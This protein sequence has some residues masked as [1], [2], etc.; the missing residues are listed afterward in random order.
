MRQDEE[1]WVRWRRYDNRWGRWD[2][3]VWGVGLIAMGLLF[4]SN[5]LGFMPWGTWRTWWPALVIFL[6]VVRLFTA[7]T[8]R[9]IGDS[10]AFLC[11]GLWF[12][13]VVNH[14]YGLD[15]HNS[16][17]LALVSV[18]LGAVARALASFVIRRDDEPEV[19]VD[20]HS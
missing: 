16:W 11:M 13:V 2:G 19:K 17:P 10:V 14:L 3:L 12:V 6:A 1:R 15:W 18:G 4:L 7:R 20:V 8:P 5:Y 9:R